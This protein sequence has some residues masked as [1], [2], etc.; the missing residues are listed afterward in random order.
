MSDEN[1]IRLSKL[2]SQKGLSSRREADR[3]IEQGLVKV[4]GQ[5]IHELGTKVNPSDQ[6]ELVQEGQKIQDNKLSLVLHKPVGYVSSQ[7]ENDYKSAM[8]LLQKNNRVFN[9]KNESLKL[10]LKNL[11]P[12]GRLDID[13]KGLIIYTQD[14]VIA[15]KIIGENSLID[16]EYFIQFK[17][18]LTSQKASQLRHGLSLD[19]KALRPA[20]IEIINDFT[21]KMTLTQGRKRQIRRMFDLLNLK[22]T[23]LKRIRIGPIKL[24]DLKE[25][26]WRLL[27]KAELALILNY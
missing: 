23:H 2:M 20:K 5:I 1:K 19:N 12:T 25:S 6:V 22:V 4:N 26:Q 27:T 16:K 3:L 15:K 18:V 21:V 13:S 8:S 9:T 17:G 14:G 7:P 24:V 10:N 11:A